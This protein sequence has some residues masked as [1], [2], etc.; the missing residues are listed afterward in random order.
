MSSTGGLT[1]SLLP[2]R[3]RFYQIF[4]GSTCQGMLV[5]RAVGLRSL[6]I[7]KAD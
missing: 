6:G 1:A 4:L 5:C 7:S 3:P 2:M